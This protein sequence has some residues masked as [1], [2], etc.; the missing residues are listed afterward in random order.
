VVRDTLPNPGSGIAR[1]IAIADQPATAGRAHVDVLT[2]LVERCNDVGI[3]IGGSDALV[4]S[5]RVR[6][7]AVRATDG[8]WGRGLQA[9][10]DFD[11]GA[12][13]AVTVRACAI[14]RSHETGIAVVSSDATIDATSIVGTQPTLDGAFGDGLFLYYDPVAG[15][16]SAGVFGSR[17]EAS[18]RAGIANFSAL[19]TLWGSVLECNQIPLDGETPTGP[20]TFDD[21]GAN[22]CGCAGAS[23]PC[24][25]LSS[26]LAPPDPLADP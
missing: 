15:P 8:L 5:T 11:T 26:M 22:S 14:E 12:R 1:G 21:Q 19:V 13:A 17:I 24:K 23:V 6:D 25:A 16:S 7:T 10:W 20:F 3:L 4:E 2:S 18:T 9:Q